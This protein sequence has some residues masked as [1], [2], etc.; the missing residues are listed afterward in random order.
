MILHAAGSMDCTVLLWL[1]IEPTNRKGFLPSRKNG[2]SEAV[3]EEQVA[4]AKIPCVG[5]PPVTEH[6]EPEE[7]WAALARL[8]N[9]TLHSFW[10]GQGWEVA[11]S[12]IYNLSVCK[13]LGS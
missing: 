9:V 5:V 2:Q 8:T 7:Q 6:R 4:P 13:G 11:V 3:G 10:E 1:A 12:L